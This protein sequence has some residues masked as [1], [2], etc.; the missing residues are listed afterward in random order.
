MHVRANRQRPLPADPGVPW[1]VLTPSNPRKLVHGKQRALPGAHA[2]TP[3]QAHCSAPY[4]A[5]E[6]LDVPSPATLDYG[7]VDVWA[8]G[9][10]L[11]HVM[12]GEPPFHR[13]MSAAGGSLA[14][15]VLK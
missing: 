4:R 15:A 1:P 3:L 12:Y 14:L 11:F 6:L 10:T 8:L 2:P 7:A 13:A 9:A 5:P